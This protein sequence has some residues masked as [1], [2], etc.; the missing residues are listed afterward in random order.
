[1]ISARD[2]Y[3]DKSFWFEGEP[4]SEAESLSGE[5]RVDV[6]IVGGGFTGLA[7]AHFLKKLEPS[8]NIALLEAQ[9]I[10][11]GASGRNAGFSMTLFGLSL[12]VTATLYGR[13]RALSAHRYM[14]EAVE[15][16]ERLVRDHGIDC[17]YERP[18]FL[19]VATTPT[20]VRRIQ[21][22]LELA[23][24]MGIRDVEWLDAE[25]VR[26]EVDSPTY[27]GAW[28]EPRCGLVNPVKLA[29]GMRTV[30]E[31][32]GVAVYERSPVTSLRLDRSPIALETP[33]GRLLADRA[34][35]ALNGYS[36]LLPQLRGRQVPAFTHIVLTEPL[37]EEVREG[38]G[39]RGRQGI[40]DARSLV[41]YYRLTAD[42]RL[43]MGGRD[44]TLPYGDDMAHDRKER[45]FR[46][47]EQDARRTFPQLSEVRFTHHWGGPVS[48]PLQL[49]PALG[50]LPADRRVFYSLGC[51]GHGVSLT[52]LNGL[53]LAELLLERQSER[54]GQFFVDRRVIPWPGEPFRMGVAA[55]LRQAFRADDAW[56]ERRGAGR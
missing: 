4:Y 33:Q 52:Q 24:R 2:T 16:L 55:V 34:V 41:H 31:G 3:E 45:T 32:Q 51:M 9:V 18:G 27:L 8:L 44:V 17:D 50:H 25:R 47:L 37:P 23:D 21:N 56:A 12:S 46:A 19:R 11:Y 7:T 1:M 40:E 26:A 29:R 10:G 38:I 43:L 15:T 13:E 6:A 14:E 20:Q 49:V 30:V 42:D 22:E 53:T 36:H 39:W 28:W 5:N 48:V 35:L 54:T